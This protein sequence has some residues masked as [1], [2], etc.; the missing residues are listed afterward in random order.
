MQRYLRQRSHGARGDV[1]CGH[2]HRAMLFD[3]LQLNAIRNAV[4]T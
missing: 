4:T 2:V 1:R 3:P